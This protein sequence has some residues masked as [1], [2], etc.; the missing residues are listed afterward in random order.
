MLSALSIR[1][2]VL[3]DKLDLNFEKGLCVF[4][5]ETGAG[6]SILLDSLSLVLGARADAGLIRHGQSSL[7]VSA[8][9]QPTPAHEVFT[10]LKEQDIAFNPAEEL[11]LRRVVTQEGKSKA[12]IND[13]PVSVS[14]LRTVGDSLVEIHGQFA[15]HKLLNPATHLSVLDAYA[16]FSAEKEAVASAYQTYKTAQ[17]DLESAKNKLQEALSQEE[18]LR[19]GIEDLEKLSPKMGEEE[20]LSTRRTGLMNSEKIITNIN[21]AAEI[22]NNE[23]QGLIRQTAVLSRLLE[24]SAQFAP[25]RFEELTKALDEAQSILTDVSFE[26]DN[27]GET[28]GDVSELPEIDN[29][30]F[31]LKDMA[32]RYHVTINEL[33]ALLDSFYDKLNSL[34]KGEELLLQ[35][36]EKANQARNTYLKTA[37]ILSEKRQKAAAKLDKSVSRELPA[38]KLE[39]ASFITQISTDETVVSPQGVDS[40]CFIAAT[41]KGMPP[42]PLN[43]IASGGELSRFMLALKVVLAHTS[44]TATLIFDEVD[45]GVGGATAAAVGNR[46]DKLSNDCQVLVV[47][48]SPQVA[49]CGKNHYRV[50]KK[51]ENNETKTS[52]C[53]LSSDERLKEIAR[54]L[55]GENITKT[56]ETMAMELLE[57]HV[58]TD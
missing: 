23:Q 2:V 46:L 58:K 15:S 38:L 45:S 33:P 5:G 53:P 39:K 26:L 22:L 7:S 6:K 3:I 48:H 10:L 35:L 34:E 4:T 30:L 31:A 43:K 57:K 32:R 52:V 28:I 42:A 11:I 55:S 17:S 44:E 12:Y 37:K 19:A 47:T 14:F 40:V 27:I 13:E 56:A 18:Y 20:E 16:G 8:A 25:N 54:M 9:F 36:Q 49:S 1:N 24:K 29:R 41:N 50:S 51:E 21:A